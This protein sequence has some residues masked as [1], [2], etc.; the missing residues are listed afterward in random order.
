MLVPV[1]EVEPGRFGEAESPPG[2]WTDEQSSAYWRECLAQSGLEHLVPVGRSWHVPLDRVLDVRTLTKLVAA[3]LDE[4]DRE[5]RGL[6]VSD[7]AGGYAL[8]DGEEGVLLPQCCG[9]LADLSEWSLVA[10]YRST[11]ETMLWVGHPWL[12]CAFVEPHLQ[13]RETTEYPRPDQI[14]RTVTVGAGALAVAVA[15]A[16]LSIRSLVPEILAVVDDLGF[17]FADSVARRTLGVDVGASP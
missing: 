7:W 10:S 4:T 11:E 17:V 12:M 16:E 2:P 13:L 1:V 14:L 8:F 5:A 15:R 9:G 6:D 3:H